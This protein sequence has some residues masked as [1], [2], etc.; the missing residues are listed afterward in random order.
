M[1][2]NIFGVVCASLLAFF[3]WGL[4]RGPRGFRV[5]EVV[6][7]VY[8]TRGSGMWHWVGMCEVGGGRMENLLWGHTLENKSWGGRPRVVIQAAPMGNVL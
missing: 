6:R 3:L 2:S 5:L 4:T 1:W 7:H 8:A